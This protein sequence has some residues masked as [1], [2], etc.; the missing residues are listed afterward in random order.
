MPEPTATLS[1][2][3]HILY[4]GGRGRATPYSSTTESDDVARYFAGP[5]GGVWETTPAAATREGAKH[6][7]RKQLIQ[8]LRRFGKGKAKWH[9]AWEV[10]QAANFV[11]QWSEHLLDWAGTPPATISTAVTRSFRKRA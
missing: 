4:M 2:V 3:A 11:E 1:I 9:D 8:N 10:T 5:G 6:L 7:P